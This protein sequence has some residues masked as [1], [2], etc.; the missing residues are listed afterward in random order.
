[1][2]EMEIYLEVMYEEGFINSKDPII[3]TL[4]EEVVDG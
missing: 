4:I 2:L 1:M 3:T